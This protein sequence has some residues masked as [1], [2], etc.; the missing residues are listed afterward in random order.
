MKKGNLRQRIKGTLIG[1]AFGVSAT[2]LGHNILKDGELERTRREVQIV[3][4]YDELDINKN[5]IL[6]KSEWGSVYEFFE[7]ENTGRYGLDLTNNQLREYLDSRE[8]GNQ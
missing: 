5:G 6:E 7:M 3:N 4:R 8:R 2:I 1:I